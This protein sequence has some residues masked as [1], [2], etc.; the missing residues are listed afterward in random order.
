MTPATCSENGHRSPAFFAGNQTMGPALMHQL[1]LA[2]VPPAGWDPTYARDAPSMSQGF[3]GRL[4]LPL[5][6]HLVLIW[7]PL[8]LADLM[9]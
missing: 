7:G 5:L 9:L 4:L 3:P 1:I 2:L 8:Q 6:G